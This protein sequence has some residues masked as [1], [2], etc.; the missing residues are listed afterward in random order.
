MLSKALR[1]IL[2]RFL[3][4]RVLPILTAIEIFRLI[5]RLRRRTP[6]P[7]A[8]RRMVTVDGSDRP[9]TATEAAAWRAGWDSNPEPKD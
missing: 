2:L 8:P 9:E 4:R 5:Q 1:L 6:E 3:P 7:V